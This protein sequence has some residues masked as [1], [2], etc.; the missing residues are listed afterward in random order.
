MIAVVVTR[1]TSGHLVRGAP[2]HSFLREFDP[3]LVYSTYNFRPFDVLINDLD[4][5]VRLLWEH[6][7]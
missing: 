3:V 6:K 4:L 2:Y 1:T 7:R 5:G